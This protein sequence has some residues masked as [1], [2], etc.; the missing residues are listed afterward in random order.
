MARKEPFQGKIFSGTWTKDLPDGQAR[1]LKP[2]ND[3]EN[4]DFGEISPDGKKT[5]VSLRVKRANNKE[6]EELRII[7]A[8]GSN[9]SILFQ[10]IYGMSANWSP[11]SQFLLI[12][13]PGIFDRII[14]NI[15]TMEAWEVEIPD[16]SLRGIGDSF[17]LS[18]GKTLLFRSSK[19]REWNEPQEIAL[20]TMRID[21]EQF[22]KI[23]DIPRVRGYLDLSPDE[24]K[25]VTDSGDLYLIDLEK[26]QIHRLWKTR[27]V[28]T[29]PSWSPDG[30]WVTYIQ[31]KS[32]IASPE[33]NWWAR[34]IK[35]GKKRLMDI[36][37]GMS[38][39]LIQWWGPPTEIGPVDVNEIVRKLLKGKEVDIKAIQIQL[40]E[41]IKLPSNAK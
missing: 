11:D 14:L 32:H 18:D 6:I 8:D 26:K 24:K 5:W 12:A 23:M 33:D 17:W 10:S 31:H 4:I 1:L 21:G 28:E 29:N 30:E 34:N 35:T 25:I 19:K 16:K 15:T 39:F 3:K 22:E 36:E 9:E 27:Y 2:V 41:D 20:Y 13:I 7:N 40:N 38:A 37:V